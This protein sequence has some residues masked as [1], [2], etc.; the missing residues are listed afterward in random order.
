M[1]LSHLEKHPEY[2][3]AIGLAGCLS[4]A[5]VFG[6]PVHQVKLKKQVYVSINDPIVPGVLLM[7]LLAGVDQL[8]IDNQ[9]F[10]VAVFQSQ[11]G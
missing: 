3:K 5:R 7:Q 2:S 8:F 6:V 10:A 9:L 4:K 11:C 1:T